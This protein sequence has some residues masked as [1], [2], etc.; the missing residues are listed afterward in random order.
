MSNNDPF[1]G[2]DD[3]GAGN[4]HDWEQIV[5][6]TVIFR[7][8]KG[9]FNVKRLDQ[10]DTLLVESFLGL[11]LDKDDD[12]SNNQVLVDGERIRNMRRRGSEGDK[13]LKAFL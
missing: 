2:L 4:R 8:G 1:I 3:D 6:A 9:H 13:P 5:G 10:E 7:R 12:S 11:L